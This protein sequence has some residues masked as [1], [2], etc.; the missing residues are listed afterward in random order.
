MFYVQYRFHSRVLLTMEELMLFSSG[1]LTNRNRS[2]YLNKLEFLFHGEICLPP[3]CLY[4]FTLS[5]EIRTQN[6]RR[7]A[8]VILYQICI[9]SVNYSLQN[10]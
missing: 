8:S 2:F 10:N 7:R 1:P 6:L 3:L 5:E 4:V 9:K